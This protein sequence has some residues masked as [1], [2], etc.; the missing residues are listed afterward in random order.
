MAG[1]IFTPGYLPYT[2]VLEDKAAQ[3]YTATQLFI[4]AG[5][6]G[7]GGATLTY[8]DGTTK[9][10]FADA[11]GNYSL[12]VPY[13][14]SGPV[15]PSKTGYR[16]TPLYILYA[17]IFANR[18]A[19]NYFATSPSGTISSPTPVYSWTK[20]K[21]ATS[22]RFQLWKG[23][24]LVYT[25]TVNSTSCTRLR[26]SLKPG[27][28][29]NYATYKWRI[30]PFVN[31]AWKSFKPYTGFTVLL[32]P[33]AGLWKNGNGELACYVSPD[34][35]Y[36]SH[37]TVTFWYVCGK[38]KFTKTYIPQVPIMLGSYKFTIADPVTGLY[39]T[40]IFKN[41]TSAIGTAGVRN[42]PGK[43]LNWSLP[44]DALWRSVAQP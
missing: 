2:D 9:T 19:Q 44:W 15:T 27:V 3:N 23:T 21:N 35:A 34:R 24:S 33:K 39:A 6:A 30:Q 5:N 10:V 43:P 18:T 17:S 4:I 13:G 32:K 37:F 11:S 31:G 40:G 28:Q 20:V 26:C 25:A 22:Y 41:P 16:L 7:V 29:L 12:T 42:C 1:Y 38:T 8:D 14:W 36:V